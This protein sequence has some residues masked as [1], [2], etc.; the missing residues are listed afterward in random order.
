MVRIRG[1]EKVGK[2]VLEIAHSSLPLMIS[3]P[4][5]RTELEKPV[6]G[7]VCKNEFYKK[8]V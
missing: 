2:E 6:S 5:E 1:M 3:E 7:L 4:T 8:Y